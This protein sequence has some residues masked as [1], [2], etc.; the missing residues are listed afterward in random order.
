MVAPNYAETRSGLARQFGL[1][2]KREPAQMLPSE[3]E[4]EAVVT[5][6]ATTDEDAEPTP[7]ASRTRAR[8]RRSKKGGKA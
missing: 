2:R 6:D 3:P 1:G 5:P 8:A 4:R 7:P